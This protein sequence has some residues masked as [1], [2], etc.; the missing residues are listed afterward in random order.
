MDLSMHRNL[1]AIDMEPY[2][3][4]LQRK[5]P[6]CPA[7]LSQMVP[8]LL[9]SLAAGLALATDDEAPDLMIRHQR[10]WTY[11]HMI[12]MVDHG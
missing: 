10:K 8:R 12:H 2:D 4:G 3:K 5:H 1:Y 6:L 9:H 7:R 11:R